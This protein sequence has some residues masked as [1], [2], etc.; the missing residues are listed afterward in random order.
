MTTQRAWR[1]EFVRSARRRVLRG[2]DRSQLIR[3]LGD[4]DLAEKL[5]THELRTANLRRWDDGTADAIFK[6]LRESLELS[7]ELIPAKED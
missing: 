3:V 1:A 2:L 4:A 5:T 6:V 7:P